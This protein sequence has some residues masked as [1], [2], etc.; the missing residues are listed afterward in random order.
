MPGVGPKTAAKWI[1]HVRDARRVVADVDEI[2]GKAGESLRDHL[3][4]VI[5]NRRI[6]AL[7]CDLDLP[8]RPADLACTT[9]WNRDAIHQVFDALEFAVLRERLF[10]YLGGGDEPATPDAAADLDA[11]T[12]VAP[13]EL[14]AWLGE[15]TPATRSVGVEVVGVTRA[16]D[17]RADASSPSPPATGAAAWVDVDQLDSDDDKALGRVAGRRRPA[18]GVARRQGPGCTRSAAHGW[19]LRGRRGRHRAGHLPGQARPARL[20]PRRPV[21]ALPAPRAPGRCDDDSGQ[22]DASTT[23]AAP[24]VRRAARPRHARALGRA[25]GGAGVAVV[26]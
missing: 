23:T 15:H 19:T 10:D 13:G 3:D 1:S 24:S 11:S 8:A 18:Q 4:D 2:P 26:R 17:A 6:N 16:V 7:V 5:R 21:A 25:G 9:E 22:L 14:S 20:R 12:H